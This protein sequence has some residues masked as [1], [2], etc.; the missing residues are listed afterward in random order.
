M[1]IYQQTKKTLPLMGG[2]LKILSANIYFF[3]ASYIVI[4]VIARRLQISDFGLYALVISVLAW[5]ELIL[6]NGFSAPYIK[7]LSTGHNIDFKRI[8]RFH[9]LSVLLTVLILFWGADQLAG[10]LGNEHLGLLFKLAALDIIPFCW[11]QR[12]LVFLNV[13]G[14]YWSY[15]LSLS[16]YATFK[17]VFMISG[18][19]IYG[20]VEAAILG[21]VLGSSL[22]ALCSWIM[23]V[24][25]PENPL[26]NKTNHTSCNTGTNL[27][28][29]IMLTAGIGIFLAADIWV[30]QG[31]G[32]SSH[33]LG[34]YGA[35][36]NLSKTLY[37]GA[38]ALILPLLPAFARHGSFLA[39]YNAERQL[40]W[41][42]WLLA[43]GI[44]GVLAVFLLGAPIIMSA[45]FGRE[46]LPAARYLHVLAPAHAIVTAGLIISQIRFQTGQE[47][48]AGLNTFLVSLVFMPLALICGSL[49]GHIA[50]PV[51]LGIMGLYLFLSGTV[52]LLQTSTRTTT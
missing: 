2:S 8:S 33:T 40:R 37:L 34:L 49:F 1:R 31:I 3:I 52:R 14:K 9:V 27:W 10:I 38:F 18:V 13:H 19:L 23:S 28:A 42:I 15:F 46:Y 51:C 30:I 43:G 50:V 32:S 29:G 39:A 47:Q 24:R 41:V 36:H 44:L 12:N 45:L 4:I 22:A 5:I 25:S 16:V 26:F 7:A 20:S 48:N 11:Y 17:A 35:A 21:M 6:A